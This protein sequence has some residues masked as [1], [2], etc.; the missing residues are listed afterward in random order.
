M[1]KTIKL[2]LRPPANLDKTIGTSE[3]NSGVGIDENGLTSTAGSESAASQR[4]PSLQ[5]ALDPSHADSGS[6]SARLHVTRR[7][8]RC[9]C[10]H[11]SGEIRLHTMGVLHTQWFSDSSIATTDEVWNEAG[12]FSAL[13]A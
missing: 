8:Q 2:G 5:A 12:R 1:G 4:S 7:E 6:V 9:N 11:G 3:Q 13:R 10:Y